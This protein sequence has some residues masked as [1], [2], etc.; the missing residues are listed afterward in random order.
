M[1][2]EELDKLQTFS[3]KKGPFWINSYFYLG[4]HYKPRYV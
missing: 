2:Q 1:A 3:D 4:G